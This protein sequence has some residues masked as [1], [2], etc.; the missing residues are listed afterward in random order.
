MSTPLNDHPQFNVIS[1]HRFLRVYHSYYGI[2][3]DTD[4]IRSSGL[5]VDETR[6]QY[7]I[8]AAGV[9]V[10]NACEKSCLKSKK[11]E[12]PTA[13]NKDEAIL[14]TLSSDQRLEVSVIFCNVES[15]VI[16]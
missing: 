2:L 15:C 4:I 8:S 5:P 3:V 14:E 12:V 7:I 1:P 13:Y 10:D 11:T 16:Q 6:L 9:L